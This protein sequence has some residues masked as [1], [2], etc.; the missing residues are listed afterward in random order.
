MLGMAGKWNATRGERAVAESG[1]WFVP[2]QRLGRFVLS[3]QRAAP[4]RRPCS[5]TVQLATSGLVLRQ[6][7]RNSSAFVHAGVLSRQLAGL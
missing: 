5:V 4:T 1:S 6:K 3:E 7:R 2:V